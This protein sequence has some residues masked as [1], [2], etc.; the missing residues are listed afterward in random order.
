MGHRRRTFRDSSHG[1][2]R[3]R[4]DRYYNRDSYRDRSLRRAYEGPRSFLEGTA[5]T[6]ESAGA[7]R[8]PA[9]VVKDIHPNIA[10]EGATQEVHRGAYSAWGTRIVS[11][12]E[13]Q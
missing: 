9:E 8:Q 1:R 12:Q 10:T 3:D 13:K 6:G 4:E 11:C 2:Y 5:E 7:R